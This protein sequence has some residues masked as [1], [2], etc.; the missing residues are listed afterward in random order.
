MYEVAKRPEI[1]ARM[2]AEIQE[3]KKKVLARGE[4]DFTALDLEGMHYT[5]AVMRVRLICLFPTY[6]C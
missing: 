4:E 2:R 5:V 3:M 6:S 1:Q